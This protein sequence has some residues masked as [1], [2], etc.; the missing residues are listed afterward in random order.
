MDSDKLAKSLKNGLQ[1]LYLIHGEEELLRIEALDLI[2]AAAKQSGAVRESYIIDNAQFNWNEWYVQAT[3][4]GLFG[5]LKLL[6]IHIPNGKLGK[7]GSEVLQKLA[8][9]SISYTS[10]VIILPKLDK[11]QI[12]SK[13]FSTIVKHATVFEAKAIS[14][15]QLP[16]WIK[17]RLERYGLTIESDA[18][19]LFAER[20]EGNL[21][22]AKQEVDKLALMYPNGHMLTLSDTQQ[23]VANVAR[24]DV[25]QLSHAWMRGDAYRVA[26]LLNGLEAEGDEPVLL[27]W[28]LAEDIRMLI[29]LAAALKQ[30]KSVQDVSRN[31]R[32]WGDKKS[33]A[34]EAVKRISVSRLITA[35]QECAKIDRQI[36]GAQEGDAWSS[37]KYLIMRLAL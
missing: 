29:Q 5:D 7:L 8:E 25:F 1:P 23:T 28:T 21:L 4:A 35:L 13:W 10:A 32:L 6:E 16:I 30:G 31:L 33:L 24:F 37:L 27:I 9:Q 17:A 3:N 22:A 36:K 14:L 11:T 19:T 15:I 20:V 34:S 2:R 26:R 12:Q 18:L